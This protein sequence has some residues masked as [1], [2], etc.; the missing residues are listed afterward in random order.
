[1]FNSIFHAAVFFIFRGHSYKKK[2]KKPHY[3]YTFSFSEDFFSKYVDLGYSDL[4]GSDPLGQPFYYFRAPSFFH[5]GPISI[6]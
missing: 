1:M 6:C 4:Y 2:K 3:F 5:G